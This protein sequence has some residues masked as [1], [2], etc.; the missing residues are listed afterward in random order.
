MRQKKKTRLQHDLFVRPPRAL[1]LLL[2]LGADVAE[3][4]EA[5]GPEEVE[6]GADEPRHPRIPLHR[7]PAER[8]DRVERVD[9]EELWAARA[10]A[11]AV[12]TLHVSDSSGPRGGKK[13][14]YGGTHV[15]DDHGGP[16]EG[17]RGAGVRADELAGVDE[18]LPGVDEPCVALIRAYEVG[19]VADGDDPVE[20]SVASVSSAVTVCACNVHCF[21]MWS[22]Y[23]WATRT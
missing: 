19:D 17:V 22:M 18:G 9:R 7:V 4:A 8:L 10:P 15:D 5:L 11:R 21:G 13:I 1:R 12:S 2:G 14:E 3:P 20:M 16:G 23:E 6:E